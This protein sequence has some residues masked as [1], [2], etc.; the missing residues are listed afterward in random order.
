MAHFQD[1]ARPPHGASVTER[2][3]AFA[4]KKYKPGLEAY[5]PE[6][7]GAGDE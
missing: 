4:H 2:L 3:E 5:D 7:G 1:Q 6:A